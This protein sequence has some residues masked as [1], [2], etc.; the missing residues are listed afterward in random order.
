MNDLKEFNKLVNDFEEVV[1]DQAEEKLV[2]TEGTVVFLGRATCP[3]CRKF[4]PKLHLVSQ[5]EQIN[6]LFVDSE[7]AGQE[8]ALREFR[9]K[10]KL[11]TVPSLLVAKAGDVKV[12]SDSSMSIE[13][14][15]SFI[16]EA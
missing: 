10:Y 13:E 11:A 4:A 3:Y 16:K 15:S 14:I 12:R 9:E 5:K 7:K 1:A 2:S 6:V 8:S